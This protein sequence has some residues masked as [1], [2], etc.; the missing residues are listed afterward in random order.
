MVVDVQ[1]LRTESSSPFLFLLFTLIRI[2]ILQLPVNQRSPLSLTLNNLSISC[3][4]QQIDRIVVT[5][6][7]S[8]VYTVTNQ[9][10]SARLIKYVQLALAMKISL[11]PDVSFSAEAGSIFPLDTG[12]GYLIAP[13]WEVQKVREV[14]ELLGNSLLG[15]C[16]QRVAV[17]VAVAATAAAFLGM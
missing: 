5:C 2:W 15:S 4:I 6:I 10:P 12:I 16:N 8:D 7:K 17:A 11:A 13:V 1:R 3:L 9:E 14:W